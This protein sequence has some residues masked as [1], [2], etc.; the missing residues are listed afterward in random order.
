MIT[1]IWNKYTFILQYKSVWF[2]VLPCCLSLTIAHSGAWHRSGTSL[3]WCVH[4]LIGTWALSKCY[5][6]MDV[7]S[8]GAMLRKCMSG[9]SEEGLFSSGKSDRILRW[10]SR[11]KDEIADQQPSTLLSSP[12]ISVHF[13]H[14]ACHSILGSAR[15]H[16]HQCKTLLVSVWLRFLPGSVG[17][18]GI[19]LTAVREKHL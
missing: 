11:R 17:W 6:Y 18:P 3:I 9:R 16:H 10:R 14:L 19:S 7:V 4:A 8:K 5:L 15:Q 13:P 1:F 2:V 12:F